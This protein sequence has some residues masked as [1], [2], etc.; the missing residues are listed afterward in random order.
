M[1]YPEQLLIAMRQDLT[2]YGVEETRT[3]AD[4]DRA[5]APE[6]GTV[7]MVINSVCGCAAG[8]ARPG[9][10][11]ALKHGVKPDKVAT[12]FAGGDDQA[13]AHLRGILVGLSAVFAFD[14]FVSEW[15]AGL[16]DAP[17]GYRI[18]RC[19]S[20]CQCSD[21]GVRPVL[22]ERNQS[23]IGSAFRC[24]LGLPAVLVF[25]AAALWAQAPATG[26]LEAVVTTE[27]GTFRFEFAPDRAPKHVA[28]F[29]ARAREGYYNGSAFHRVVA[30]G[31]IQGGDPLLKNPKTPKNLWGT[32]GLSLLPAEFSELQHER[33]VVSTVSI[34]NKADSDGAQ[35]FV[36]VVPQP[37]LDGHYS[38][39]GRVTEGMDVVERISRVPADKDG[40]VDAPVRIISV[41]IEPKK[42]EPF[43]NAHGQRTAPDGDD[44]D[45]A[46][47]DED[48]DGAGLGA[49]ECAG[50]SEADG[51]GLVQRDGFSPDCE[52]ICGAGRDGRIEREWRSGAS[53]G[54][55]G[56]AGERRVS[57]GCEAYAGD[58]FDGARGRSGFGDDFV[59][60]WFWMRR[61]HL[62]GQY[63]AFGRVVEGLDVLDAFGKE[64]VDGESS[65][66]PD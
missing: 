24:A 62:D 52:G 43:L 5:L 45:H 61:P 32:G 11:M 48:P 33:G 10:G 51:D 13:V 63:S 21:S 57:R 55:L 56:A 46:G 27:L 31:M 53:G 47:D 34:P 39:F 58:C 19:V 28:Q 37:S 3:P 35:F 12:V 17:A 49:G 38:A 22:R 64:E 44:E 60:S 41:T 30:N 16:H 8:K 42:V 25:S 26:E 50:V 2:Q 23:A 40:V 36:C 6:N 18:A 65:E 15:Q 14:R 20:D 9:V 59:S 54:P 7:M 4:V 29:I 66:T 1:A